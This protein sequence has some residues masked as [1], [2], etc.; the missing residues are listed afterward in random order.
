MP[1]L[2]WIG[3]DA[4]EK[5]HK[6]MPFRLLELVEELSCGETNSGN[7]I[8][9][10]DNLHALEALL[11]RYA[12]KVKC[13]YIDPPYNTGVDDRDESG[14][15]SGWVY[16]DSVNSPEIR[17]WFGKVVG[18]ESDDLSRHDKWLCM[19]QQRLALLK[20]FLKDDGVIFV[21]IDENEYGNDSIY[22]GLTHLKNHFFA[23]IGN[24]K[25]TGEEFECA[26]YI[27]H[28]MEGVE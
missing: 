8:M 21:S 3:K 25:S 10:G 2:N 24:L 20:N 4:V 1:T 19:M 23:V 7:L 27:A 6:E 14:K 13:I 12:E 26:E 15:R 18:A 16:S 5:H 17:A 22:T 9:Q 11:P 28:Q